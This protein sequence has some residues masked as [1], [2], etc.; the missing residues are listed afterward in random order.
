MP[1]TSSALPIAALLLLTAACDQ[2]SGSPPTESSPPVPV[3]TSRS[4]GIDDLAT[5]VEE[6]MHA[7]RVPGAAFALIAGGELAGERGLGL[8]DAA[9]GTPVTEETVFEAASL[10]KPVVAYMVMKMA[11]RGEIDLDRPLAEV[12]PHPDL[13][14]PRGKQLTAR[15]VLSHTTGLPNWRPGRW[16]DE[17]GP[18]S[19]GFDPGSR[20]SYSG[21]GFEYL[22][23]VVEEVSGTGLEELARREVFGP[24][25]MSHSSFL[26]DSTLPAAMP[27]DFLGETSE[28][29]V[30]GEVNAA[31][32]LHT[33]AGDYARFVAEILRPRHLGAEMLAPQVEVEVEA[34]TGVAW[35]L[36]WGLEPAGGTFWH[37][38]DNGDSRC[39][40][41]AS[42]D[43][44]DGLVLFTNSRNGL[45]IAEAAFGKLF[46]EG[47][48]AFAWIDYDRYDSPG[49]RIRDRLLR[50]G[51]GGG[52][53]EISAAFA[54]LEGE[55]DGLTEDLVN[56]IGYDLLGRERTAAAVAVFRWNAG[57]HPDA[58][59][60]YDSLGEGLA[61][62]GD[63]AAAIRNYEKSLELNPENENAVTM[64]ARLRRTPGRA[65]G[66][67][68]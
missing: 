16:T 12:L 56:R 49:F 48:P 64:L 24:L 37:W 63:V 39:F 52:A 41:M 44:G 29:R 26:Y 43:T 40:V 46:G 36:G 14:D 54:G 8:A 2:R 20:F 21:E 61:E 65:A 25:G 68:E 51:I 15:Q 33:T 34:G 30:G 57:R 6:L 50:A 13:D 42:R 45:A 11:E 31:G 62:S 55:G 4:S 27:H 66:A 22:R 59:N 7:G 58:W 28:K 38:G 10:S 47:R 32:S 18:L 3:G 5:T 19:L 9:A 60:V 53:E 35:G 23:L 17:P 67:Q 1:K